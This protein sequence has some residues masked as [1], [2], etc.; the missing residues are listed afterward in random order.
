MFFTW[1][2][3]H[4]KNSSWNYPTALK[5]YE[6]DRDWNILFSPSICGTAWASW[7]TY[8]TDIPSLA[9]VEPQGN[10]LLS[11]LNIRYDVSCSDVFLSCRDAQGSMYTSD[12]AGLQDSRAPSG[13]ALYTRSALDTHRLHQKGHLQRRAS[14]MRVK[15]P[16]LTDVNFIDKWSRMVF[17]ITF[18]LFNVVYWLYH[19]HLC[20]Q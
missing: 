6:N 12:G 2:T 14:Q 8:L 11:T 3:H 20:M 18:I 13:R 17:S 9:Q 16:N 15:I 1:W 10:M 19:V 5:L 4:Y 7:G